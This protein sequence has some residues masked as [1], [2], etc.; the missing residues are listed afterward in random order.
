M[1]AAVVLD[2]RALHS[3]TPKSLLSLLALKESYMVKLQML[4]LQMI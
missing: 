2:H 4:L 3:A 1:K